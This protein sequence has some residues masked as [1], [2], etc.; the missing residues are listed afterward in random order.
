MDFKVML[1]GMSARL[2]AAY[3]EKAFIHSQQT[4]GVW[5]MLY[6]FCFGFFERKMV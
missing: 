2:L 4:N 3:T 5:S 1:I 6:H